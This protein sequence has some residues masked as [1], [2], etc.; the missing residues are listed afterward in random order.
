[1]QSQVQQQL[2]A[3]SRKT[4]SGKL[5]EIKV[6]VSP[7]SVEKGLYAALGNRFAGAKF[8][9]DSSRYFALLGRN[10]SNCI[11]HIH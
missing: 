5:S 11:L 7:K 3:I 4:V 10:M 8:I 9:A 1:M 2:Q 6:F